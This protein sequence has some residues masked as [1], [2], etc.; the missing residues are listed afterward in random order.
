MK[1]KISSLVLI[2]LTAGLAAT[3]QI[4]K[5]NWF[6]NG[7][8]ILSFQA[9]LTKDS[10]TYPNSGADHS[11]TIHFRSFSIGP[12]LNATTPTI[13]LPSMPSINYGITN[14]LSG[15]IFISTNLIGLNEGDSKSSFSLIFI[16]PTIRYYFMEQT[17]FIPF[18]EGKIGV[19]SYK[20][21]DGTTDKTSLF[22]WYLGT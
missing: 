15:G 18:G 12:S 13:G 21:G 9:G 5:G 3:A 22:G 1:N 6:V 4:Q 16:G 10:Y 14:K 11:S 17:K 7:L 19:G 2:L 8:N 20:T